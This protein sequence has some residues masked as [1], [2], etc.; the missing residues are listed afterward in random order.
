MKKH[1]SYNTIIGLIDIVEENSHIVN[2]KFGKKEQDMIISETP[3]IKETYKQIKEYLNGKR[4]IFNIPIKYQGTVFQNKVWEALLTISYGTTKSYQDIAN[5]I[6]N[7][8]ACQAVGMACRT[9]PLPI[10]IP[11]H[12]VIGKDGTLTGFGGGLGVKEHLL[13]IE[14]GECDV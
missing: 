12:R 4:K 11:C 9:N 5:Q 1:F 10:L 6:G 7:Y 2:I 14:R 8:K 13:R 3:L